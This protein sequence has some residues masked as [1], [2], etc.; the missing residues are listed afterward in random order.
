MFRLFGVNGVSENLVAIEQMVG[1]F[2]GG[3]ILHLTN[4]PSIRSV[5]IVLGK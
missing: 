3:R 1:M 2:L 5:E 4:V